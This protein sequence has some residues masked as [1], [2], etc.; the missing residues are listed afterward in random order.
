MTKHFIINLSMFHHIEFQNE[1]RA[2][3]RSN[4]VYILITYV[5]PE[6]YFRFPNG[7]SSATPKPNNKN[8]RRNSGGTLRQ[9]KQQWQK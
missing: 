9:R 2:I 1:S 4:L 6:L 3:L 7:I 8:D 5:G